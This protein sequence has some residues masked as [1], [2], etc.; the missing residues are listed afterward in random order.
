MLFD[1]YQWKKNKGSRLKILNNLSEINPDILCLQEFY[2]SE[3]KNN[4][5]NIIDVKK[6]LK[7]DYHHT[8]YTVSRQSIKHWGIATF[9]KFPI[10]NEGK[11]IFDTKTNNLCIYSDILINND[12]IRVYNIHLQSVSFSKKDNHFIEDIASKN[13]SND[14]ENSKN[15]LNRLKLAFIK[16]AQQVDMINAHLKT[17]KY[18]IILCGDFNDTGASYSYENLSK[19]LKDSF[20]EKGNGL[21]T[22]YAG[23]WPQFR[24]DYLLHSP[25]LICL[26]YIKSNKTFTDHF[27]ITA[28]LKL[29]H[30]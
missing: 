5:N 15:I 4:F 23:K 27:P 24:I 14:V 20:L 30:K 9:S 17:C 28:I 2:T 25:D 11:M 21:G 6:L 1:L 19:K 13:I 16:R 29:H 12:T 18:K 3:E 7:I 26:N 8:E 10:L 22:T